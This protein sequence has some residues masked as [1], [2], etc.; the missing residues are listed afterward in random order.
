M[1]VADELEERRR[2]GVIEGQRRK[3]MLIVVERLRTFYATLSEERRL[4]ADAAF[5][6]WLTYDQDFNTDVR[7]HTAL[8]LVT[9]L[10]IVAA[11]PALLALAERFSQSKLPG[12]AQWAE[13]LNKAAWRLSSDPAR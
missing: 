9:S 4:E 6:S 5:A 2:E 11:A 3:D 13:T 10:K 1:K 8:Q 12:A 7:W